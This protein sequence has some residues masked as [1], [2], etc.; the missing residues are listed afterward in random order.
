MT[1]T[2]KAYLIFAADEISYD[3]FS[4]YKWVSFEDKKYPRY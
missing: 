4:M 1:K 2:G 3:S